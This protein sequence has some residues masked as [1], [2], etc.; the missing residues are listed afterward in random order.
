M[1]RIYE[2]ITTKA[3]LT[4]KHKKDLQ[5]KRGFTEETIQKYRF[6]SGGTQ[7]LKLEKEIIEQFDKE[8]L[9][10]SGVCVKSG[11]GIAISPMLLDDRIIIHTWVKV[12]PGAGPIT[13]TAS[14]SR[15]LPDI[16]KA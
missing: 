11:K 8:L 1:K 9:L 4:P 16:T 13:I 5:E 6:F 2:Y 10:T 3:K 14:M 12:Q 7:F 15:C